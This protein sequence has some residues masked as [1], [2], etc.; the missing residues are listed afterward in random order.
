MI[1]RYHEAPLD[2]FSN[3]QQL[4]DGDYALVHLFET[5]KEYFKAFKNA[6]ES[7]RDVILDNSIFELGT[8]FD[9]DRYA[10]WV[11]EL[12]PTW[13]IVP[14]CWKKPHET[15][16]M[17]EEFVRDHPNLPGKRIG[18]A[19]GKTIEDVAWC[20]KA[21]EPMCDMIAFNLDGSYTSELPEIGIP[22]CVRMSVGRFKLI[23]DLH[24]RGVI[25]TK[26][27]HH[28]LGCGIPQ[29]MLW[30]PR[31]ADWIRSV[32]TCNPVIH[33]MYNMLYDAKLPGM[34]SKL[35]VK[36]C[37]CMDRQISASGWQCIERNIMSFKDY[38]EREV[39]SQWIE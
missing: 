18:V 12:Q 21:L 22:Y 6:V 17:F 10:Y 31:D 4:T 13:Y 3:V 15:V 35:S 7:G 9:G 39:G 33:G 24:T 26:K 20:Y 29:E 28:L 14:D 23:R 1:K 27:P 2:V 5:N 32:D 19:Q 16:K 30:Y 38:C 11:E 25:N 34:T 37:D 36:M 8:A